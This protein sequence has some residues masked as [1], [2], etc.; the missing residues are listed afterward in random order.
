[1]S[2]DAVSREVTVG[3]LVRAHG[4]RGEVV[5]KRY[6]EA[7]EVLAAGASLR[8][9][10]GNH[11]LA[12]VVSASRPHKREWIVK[13]KGIDTRTEAEALAGVELF[14]DAE[15]LPP[16]EEGTYYEFQ[17]MGL[18]VVTDTGEAL[19]T[20]EEVIATGARDIY[21]VRGPRGEVLLPA[22]PQVIHRVDVPGGTMVVTPLPGLLPETEEA[23]E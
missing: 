10:K 18:H 17:L 20:L 16:L 11:A 3:R 15:E 4:I 13:F 19:G 22:I 6:G 8:G 21:V 1:M 12:L 5:V 14:L 23:A 9:K 2:I 7:E